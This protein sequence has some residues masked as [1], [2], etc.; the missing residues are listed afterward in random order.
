MGTWK[1]LI[2]QFRSPGVLSFLSLAPMQEKSASWV[3]TSGY[4]IRTQEAMLVLELGNTRNLWSRKHI[5]QTFVQDSA[6]KTTLMKDKG[7]SLRN[8]V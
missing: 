6:V 5:K 7:D 4:V 1:D 8:S 2:D 3:N